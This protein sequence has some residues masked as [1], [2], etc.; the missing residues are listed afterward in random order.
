MR[1]KSGKPLLPKLPYR[2][3][4][5]TIEDLK[6]E[7]EGIQQEIMEQIDTKQKLYDRAV[8]EFNQLN[9]EYS[10]QDKPK[11]IQKP[12]ENKDGT[13]RIE[14]LSHNDHSENTQKQ[15][16]TQNPVSKETPVS[17]KKRESEQKALDSSGDSIFDRDEHE[18]DIL[19]GHLNRPD[20]EKVHD[21]MDQIKQEEGG[22]GNESEEDGMGLFEV[23]A[24]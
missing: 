7:Y 14:S 9:V 16:V 22:K 24:D 21:L 10:N 12:S 4:E 17:V 13:S 15:P 3:L 8:A 19:G 6:E 18:E 23:F 2:E 1:R 11:G 5:K 20:R